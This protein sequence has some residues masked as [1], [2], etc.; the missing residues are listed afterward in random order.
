MLQMTLQSSLI[1]G[2]LSYHI[3]AR[4]YTYKKE[5]RHFNERNL[6]L[7]Y[8]HDGW[9]LIQFNNSY[10]EPSV[11]VTK[12]FGWWYKDAYQGV[13]VGAVT[14][15]GDTPMGYDLLPMGQVELGYRTGPVT[16][17]LGWIPS[18]KVSVLTLH[19]KYTF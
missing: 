11:M 1:F 5:T 3:G 9:A 6:T 13:K 2:G 19:W 8:E 16:S 17:V 18:G 7:G 10:Y 14:G 4:E 12:S 15:Y